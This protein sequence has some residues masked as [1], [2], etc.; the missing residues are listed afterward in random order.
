MYV[1]Q[2]QWNSVLLGTR[3][4]PSLSMGSTIASGATQAT[5][6]SRYSSCYSSLSCSRSIWSDASTVSSTS[7]I[8]VAISSVLYQTI[9]GMNRNGETFSQRTS[10]YFDSK[11][12]TTGETGWSSERRPAS[13]KFIASGRLKKKKMIS[14][15]RR[16][17]ISGS[18][19]AG[20]A[21]PWRIG[22]QLTL[23]VPGEGPQ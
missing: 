20:S 7:S 18:A 10:L 13:V 5:L 9:R 4:L 3:R 6:P 19:G 17:C 12:Q 8:T 16:T 21:P 23:R 22:R 14:S 1:T 11:M 15:W 2:S